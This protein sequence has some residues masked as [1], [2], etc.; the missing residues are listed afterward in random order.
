[1][2]GCNS[3]EDHSVDNSGGS[4]NE[5]CKHDYT[6]DT[7]EHAALAASLCLAP[8]QSHL[9]IDSLLPCVPLATAGSNIGSTVW[10]NPT[11][12]TKAASNVHVQSESAA[13]RE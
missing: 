9:P 8:R 7:F 11:A 2:L 10:P 13:S 5:P 3:K 12:H 6:T 4:L 1:M